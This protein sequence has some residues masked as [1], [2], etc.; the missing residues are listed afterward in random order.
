MKK[1]NKDYIDLINKK[2]M[3]LFED[4][5]GDKLEEV[6]ILRNEYVEERRKKFGDNPDFSKMKIREKI[7]PGMYFYNLIIV[8]TLTIGRWK[9]WGDILYTK[10]LS[11]DIPYIN[12]KNNDYDRKNQVIDML[13]TC[14]EGNNTSTA[15]S[16]TNFVR[17]I[18][19]CIKPV[20]HHEGEN[21]EE[22]IEN[23]EKLI[24]GI[25]DY[26][27]TR[28]YENFSLEALLLYPGDYLGELAAEYLG[29][30]G[31]A[32]FP[33]PNS[34]VQFMVEVLFTDRKS[35]F[36]KVCDPCTGSSRMLLYASNY[37]LRLCGQDINKDIID[38]SLVNGYLY[39]PWAV[40]ITEE[41]DSLIDKKYKEENI[42]DVIIEKLYNESI[43][44]QLTL[45]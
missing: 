3:E 35:K 31:S 23:A 4:L 32:Y 1:N 14:I 45:F 42:K 37:T 44:G 39:M 9:Y 2:M 17:Y 10:D 33:T 16:F 30:N 28:Y 41:I 21:I 26:S 24:A 13:R 43:N 36:Q 38:V 34:V 29:D 19:Y 6:L 12:F 25:D 20:M 27:L 40:F 22:K 18:L 11:K 5:N 7:Y 8:D 15:S